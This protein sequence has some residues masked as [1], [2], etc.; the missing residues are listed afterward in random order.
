MSS[1]Y[2]HETPGYVYLFL[3]N[4]DPVPIYIGS[5]GDIA[6]RFVQHFR[7]GE[8]KNVSYESVSKVMYCKV[9]T[10][11]YASVIEAALIQAIRPKCNKGWPVS[12]PHTTIDE[13]SNKTWHTV[14]T[15]SM[16]DRDEG[17]PTL[18][19][20]KIAIDASNKFSTM[21]GNI[22]KVFCDNAKTGS[23][24][25]EDKERAVDAEQKNNSGLD[26]VL[27]A[28]IDLA[29]KKEKDA[30]MLRATAELLKRTIREA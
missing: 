29:E 24:V 13:I 30:E 16:V 17:R 18:A 5:T 6:A 25:T 26:A 27:K 23:A 19:Q 8:R 14:T 9:Q 2:S 3:T 12:Q 28:I 22:I 7:Y 11:F 4:D 20:I 15:E 21:G 10:R 1:P